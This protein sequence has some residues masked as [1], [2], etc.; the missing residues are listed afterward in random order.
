MRSDRRSSPNAVRVAL[1]GAGYIA[2]WHAQALQSVDGVELVAVCDRAMAKAEALAQ[3][4]G[5]KHVYTSLEDMLAA[6]QLDAVHVLLPPSGH[7]EAARTVLEADVHVFLEKP[8]CANAD[9]C[10]TLV[11]LAEERGLRLG[12]D[13]NF[14]FTEIYE[15]LQRDV[16]G[17][18]LGLIDDVVITWHREMPQA[19]HGP[20]DAWM[21][22]DPLNILMEVG[23]HS[24]AHLL[25]LLG[26]PDGLD[27]QASNGVELPTGVPFYR[28]WHGNAAK[29]RTSV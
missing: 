24:A 10:D 28:R 3:K 17:G 19:A 5:A 26:E 18:V 9:D 25:D 7:F 16:R 1:L 22:R 20:F 14:L 13:H 21:L 4:F 29:G 11:R 12:V 6:E 2:D 8:M 15:Q 23:S 27:V